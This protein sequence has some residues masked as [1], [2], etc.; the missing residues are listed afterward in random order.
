MLEGSKTVLALGMFDG[1]HEGHK[2]IVATAKELANAMGAVCCVYTFSN[3]PAELLG[4]SVKKLCTNEERVYLLED[5]GADQVSMEPFTGE[6]LHMRPEAFI[7]TLASRWDLTGIVAGFNYSFGDGGE[8]GP[9]LLI[10]AGREKGFIAR[11]LPAVEIEGETVSSSAIRKALEAGDIRKASAF[12]GR[13]YSVSGPVSVRDGIIRLDTDSAITLPKEGTYKT[14]ILTER[15]VYE[16]TSRVFS[17]KDGSYIESILTD[18]GMFGQN[19]EVLL[20]FRS[21]I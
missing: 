2:K 10:S 15:G 12:L 18:P 1:V 11:I 16:S 20:V 7:E 14:Q 9:D 21:A 17:G 6:M 13:S 5:A 3:H 4:R 8:G 19:Y